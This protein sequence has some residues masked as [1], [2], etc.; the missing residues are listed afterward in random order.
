MELTMQMTRRKFV[1]LAAGG[2]AA[3]AWGGGAE[4]ASSQSQFK[5]IAF[6]AFAI[7]DPRPVFQLAEAIFPNRGAELSNVWRTRQFEYQWL[8]TISG[9]YSD[10]WHATDDALVFAARQLKLDLTGEDRARLMQSLAELSAWPDTFPA[11]RVLRKKGPQLA[12]LSNMTGN[13]LKTGIVKNDLA[14]FFDQ[15]FST[16]QLKTYKPAPGAYQMAATAF[17]LRKEEILYVAFA[18]WDVAGA[19]WFGYPTYWLNRLNAA[20]EE[21]GALPDATG[22]DLNDLVYF[23]SAG[24]H[25]AR[26]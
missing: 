11:L 8:R 21:L 12:L 17:G 5:A 16:D 20:V 26:R 7:F 25:A 4:P 14:G 22:S 3:T 2:I 6:D 13:M 1:T 24:D 19:K 18:G 9:H 23:L 10:F 15:V